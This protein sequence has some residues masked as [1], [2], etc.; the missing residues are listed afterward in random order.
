MALTKQLD[1]CI[2]TCTQCH[3]V[4]LETLAHCLQEGG[5]HAKLEHITLLMDCADICR[6]SADFMIRGSA[7]H[8]STCAVCAD[9]CE[10]CA[11]SCERIGDDPV[12][13]EC[14]ETCR[15]CAAS[16]RRMAGQKAA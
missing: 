7:L 3:Q 6:T 8:V 16:C 5:E 15:R 1:E 2:D 12:M 14:A 13:S 10:E 4:C 11:Q 9:V